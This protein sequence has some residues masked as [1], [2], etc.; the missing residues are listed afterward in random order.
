MKCLFDQIEINSFMSKYKWLECF[1]IRVLGDTRE[2]NKRK[3]K[4]WQYWNDWMS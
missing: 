4:K 3:R 2:K 1:I